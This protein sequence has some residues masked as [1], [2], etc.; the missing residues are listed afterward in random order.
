MQIW[1]CKADGK[2]GWNFYLLMLQQEIFEIYLDNHIQLCSR[3]C[4]SQAGW[5]PQTAPAATTN[6]RFPISYQKKCVT[7]GAVHVLRNHG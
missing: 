6:S 2:T 1:T 3:E 4:Q 7:S 5:K